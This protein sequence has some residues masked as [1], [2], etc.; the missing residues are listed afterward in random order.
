MNNNVDEGDTLTT[1]DK[2][3]DEK[4]KEDLVPRLLAGAVLGDILKL[5]MQLNDTC[6][7]KANF[8]LAISGLILIFILSQF[9][10]FFNPNIIYDITIQIGFFITVLSALAAAI[11][12]VFVIKPKIGNTNKVNLFYYGSFCNNITKEEYEIEMK[13]LVKNQEDIIKH[14]TN[15]IYDLGKHDLLPRFKSVNL[16]SKMLIIS[17][18]AGTVTSFLY[19]YIYY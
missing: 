17:L 14:Y 12:C 15:E 5:H 8:V 11:L 1:N 6:D 18:A 16:A 9:M 7:K 13:K 10:E 4:E 19:M 2:K 3:N